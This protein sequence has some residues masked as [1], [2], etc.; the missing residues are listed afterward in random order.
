MKPTPPGWPRAS[1]S[2]AYVN[3]SQAIAWL[4]NAFGFEVRLR[5]DGKDGKVEHSELTY[6]EALF[7]VGD[8][9]AERANQ[10]APSELAGANTQKIMVYVDEL[11]AHLARARAAGATI[12]KGIETHDYGEAYWT[13]RSYSC[14]DLGQ[15][16]WYFAE[17]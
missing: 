14:L 6:G 17:R 11:D 7:M 1:S 9:R 4:C 5:V 2:L 15:H 3:A 8:A 16:E 10:R 12:L 13:D